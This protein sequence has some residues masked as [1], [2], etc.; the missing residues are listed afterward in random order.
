MASCPCVTLVG[1]GG[2]GKTRLAL[3]VARRIDVAFGEGGWFVDLASVSEPSQVVAKIAAALRAP[4]VSTLERDAVEL[5]VQRARS[6]RPGFVLDVTNEA[7][8]R[9]LCQRLDALPLAIELPAARCAVAEPSEMLAQL[10][11]GLMFLDGG[12]RDAPARHRTIR[13]AIDWSWSLLTDDERRLLAHA[14][15]FVGGFTLDAAR[16]VGG[17]ALSTPSD[18]AGLVAALARKSLLHATHRNGT[19][20]FAMLDT[21]REYSS[22]RLVDLGDREVAARRHAE[23]A[24]GLCDQIAALIWSPSEA[25]GAAWRD[26]ERPNR[27]A[28]AIPTH[29]HSGR[30]PPW[31]RPA[32]TPTRR[33]P[34]QTW[35]TSKGPR[36]RF[37]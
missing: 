5:F 31:R 10:S 16:A 28:Q 2:V 18:V 9:Q 4:N 7:P 24:A 30:S 29:P 32:G 20:R 37:G 11:E 15:V 21:V 35:P 23:W 8:I 14:S 34:Q 25:Q 3:Q 12:P 33:S 13:A 17:A 27:G 6:I 19:T 1:V 26:V 22:Q 36:P